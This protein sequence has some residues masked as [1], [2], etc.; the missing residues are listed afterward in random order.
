MKSFRLKQL[1]R[2][3]YN[4][5]LRMHITPTMMQGI[6]NVLAIEDLSPHEKD[7]L[8]TKV[9]NEV[10]ENALLRYLA[11]LT[12]WEQSSFEQWLTT[13][14]THPDMMSELLLLYPE[15]GKILSEEILLL[16]ENPRNFVGY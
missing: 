9:G 14:A 2:V 16:S 13:H 6:E 5:L 8:Y 7:V 15:F 3:I 11:N 4:N 1:T 12:E 10:L